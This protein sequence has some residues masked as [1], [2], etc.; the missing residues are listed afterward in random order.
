MRAM[1]LR[2][3]QRGAPHPLALAELPDPVPAPDEILV[4]V[5]ACAI[6]RTDLHVIDGDLPARTLPIVPGHQVVGHVVASGAQAQTREAMSVT[7]A[8][9]ALAVSASVRRSAAAA[10]IH[11]C[12]AADSEPAVSARK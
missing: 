7:T 11:A 8:V 4:R 6:C 3:Q 1:L 9:E 5:S 12:A 2:E 10:V